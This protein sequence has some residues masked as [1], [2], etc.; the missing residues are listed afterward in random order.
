M[1]NFIKDLVRKAYVVM[2][3]SQNAS[4]REYKLLHDPYTAH[5]PALENRIQCVEAASL[6]CIPIPDPLPEPVLAPADDIM[7]RACDHTH[8]VS[9]YLKHHR[10]YLRAALLSGVV[11]YTNGVDPN[12]PSH[13]PGGEDTAA[14]I[15]W[16]A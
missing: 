16:T 2:L 3:D 8:A 14:P 5:I 11:V 13:R 15:L 10:R 9:V 6:A 12:N 7:T 4:W 1:G